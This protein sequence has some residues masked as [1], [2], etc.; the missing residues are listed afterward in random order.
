L[1]H[2]LALCLTGA[3]INVARQSALR[4]AGGAFLLGVVLF[5]GSLYVLALDGP[6]WFGPVTPIGGVSF[7]V[8]WIALAISA[9]DPRPG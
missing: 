7:I 2:A 1:I 9:F 3:L 4:V 6:R 5:S 8:G